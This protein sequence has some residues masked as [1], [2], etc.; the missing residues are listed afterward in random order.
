M[1]EPL[2]N[3]DAKLRATMRTELQRIQEELGV[4]TIYVTHDQTEAMT[5]GDRIAILDDGILQQVGTPLE[6]YHTPNNEFVA[7][8]IGDPSMNF[9]EME[10]DRNLLVGDQF[11]YPLT[12]AQQ[13]S[14]GETRD[15]TFGIR[16]E[17]ID[18]ETDGTADLEHAFEVTVDVVEPR[19][20][21]NTI[22]L[23]FD[24]S[25]A[26]PETFTA[27]VSGLRQLR[28][29]D[30]VVATFPPNAIH[31]FDTGSGR[32]LHNRSLDVPEATEQIV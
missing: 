29:G 27:T 4:T 17:D 24:Q 12:A 13:E 7:G 2:S 18:I 19:G 11:E 14:V 32:A 20:D 10:A 16:P 21:E 31:L 30:S 8:F 1:D 25:V 15:V 22:H 28:A 3:L 5:M 9:F 6:C 26:E 23:T